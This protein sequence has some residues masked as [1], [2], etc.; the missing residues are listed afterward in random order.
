MWWCLFT[1]CPLSHSRI[2]LKIVLSEHVPPFR[3]LKKIGTT[4]MDIVFNP[5]DPLAQRMDDSSSFTIGTYRQIRRR[6]L[7]YRNGSTTSNRTGERKLLTSIYGGLILASVLF[8][9]A[10][11]T[12]LSENSPPSDSAIVNH[13]SSSRLLGRVKREPQPSPSSQFKSTEEQIQN[14]HKPKFTECDNYKP[15]VEEGADRGTTLKTMH[16][17]R[18]RCVFVSDFN[19]TFLIAF[20]P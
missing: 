20:R 15:E 17:D 6:P 19:S 11:S 18:Q 13:L 10:V 3:R 4:K 8:S 7:S 1:L 16:A 9:A 14:K 5:D 12:Q 2:N